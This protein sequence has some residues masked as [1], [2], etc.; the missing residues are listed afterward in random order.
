V[1]QV[2]ITLALVAQIAA[3]RGYTVSDIDIPD[4]IDL[5][6]ENGLLSID[7]GPGCDW[8]TP[9]LNVEFLPG[10]GGVGAIRPL[11]ESGLCNIYISGRISEQPCAQNADGDCDIAAESA[12]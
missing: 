6:T 10:S 4:Q 7:Y 12:R 8:V 1:I 9:D 3:P 2:A 5:A 11:D